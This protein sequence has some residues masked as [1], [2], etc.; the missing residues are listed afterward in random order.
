MGAV[1][2]PPPERRI[3]ENFHIYQPVAKGKP[4]VDKIDIFISFFTPGKENAIKRDYLTQKCVDAGLIGKNVRDKDRAMRNLVARAKVDYSI[5]I[6]NDCDGS[7]YYRPTPKESAQLARNN[8]REDKKAI[9][10]FKNNK[11]NKALA[12]DYKY[13]RVVNE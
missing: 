11:P 8:K 2:S 5:Q 3:M 7:G 12:E 4:K 10:T 6:T 1:W 9:S 13:G